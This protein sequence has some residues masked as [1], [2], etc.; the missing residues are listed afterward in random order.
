MQLDI[1]ITSINIVDPYGGVVLG[2][3]DNLGGTDALISTVQ[4]NFSS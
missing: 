4:K 2:V 3:E 1:I